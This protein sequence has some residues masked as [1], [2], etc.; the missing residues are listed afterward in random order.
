MFI[1]N[2][3][4]LEKNLIFSLK[5]KRL[6]KKYIQF[7][8]K[9]KSQINNKSQLGGTME[10]TKTTKT[11]ET[12]YKGK[13]EYNE[14]KNKNGKTTYSISMT[15]HNALVELVLND[16]RWTPKMYYQLTKP[17]VS[18]LRISR[19]YSQIDKT[20]KRAPKLFVRKLLCHLLKLIQTNK[21]FEKFNFTENSVVVLEADGSDNNDL[22]KKVYEPM[23]FTMLSSDES[24]EKDYP[25]EAGGLMMSHIKTIFK[26]TC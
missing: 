12:K 9:N 18:N 2:N 26:T 16:E 8:L 14:K 3:K 4:T 21:K 5:G 1:I 19:I 22:V 17:I 6:L 23:G 25:G 7:Y 15:Y 11:T 24:S 10:T 13:I 20:K